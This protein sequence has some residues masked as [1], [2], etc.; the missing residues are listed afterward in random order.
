M[1]LISCHIENF[2]KLHDFDVDFTDRIHITCEENGWGKSTFA[3]FVRAMF[4]GLEGKRRTKIEENDFQRYTPW[5]GGVFGGR[6][7]FETNGKQYTLRR[8][9]GTG[10]EFE[11]RE[12]ATNL[13]STDFTENIGIEL[14]RVDRESFMRTVFIGQNDCITCTTDDINSKIGN[15]TDNTNDMNSYAKADE[16]LKKIENALTPRSIKGS[17]KKREAEINE[18]RREVALGESIASSIATYQNALKDVREQCEKIKK[19]KARAVE[20]QTRVASLQ[21]TLAKREEWENLKAVFKTR[22]E[23]LDMARKKFPGEVPEILEIEKAMDECI[24][25][26]AVKERV[27]MYALTDGEKAEVATLETAFGDQ[28]PSEAEIE[29]IQGT[30]RQIENCRK[31]LEKKQTDLSTRQAI[32]S[33]ISQTKAPISPLVTIGG[34]ALV[35]GFVLCFVAIVIGVVVA[36]VGA[37]LLIAGLAAGN[38]KKEPEIPAEIV[39]LEKQVEQKE[40]EL[41]EL[42]QQVTTYL[43]QYEHILGSF[44]NESQFAEQL[45]TLNSKMKTFASLSGKREKYEEAKKTYDCKLRMVTEFLESVSVSPSA[46]MRKQLDEMKQNVREYQ[47][48]YRLFVEVSDNLKRFESGIDVEALT[49][50]IDAKSLPDLETLNSEVERLTEEFDKKQEEIREKQK[51]LEELQAQFEEWEEKKERLEE[52]YE[53]QER[54][55]AKY[56]RIVAAREYLSRAKES[57]TARYVGPILEKFEEYYARIT[58]DDGTQF[59]MDANTKVTVEEY[60][61]QRDTDTLSAGYQDLIGFCLRIAFVDAMYQEETPMLIMDDPFVNLDDKKMK[62]AKELLEYIAEKYQIIYFTCSESRR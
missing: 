18:L 43:K 19:D 25:M 50:E 38:K 7:T 13:P 31:E 34:I 10:A 23:E 12:T 3:A 9:F 56:K 26:D 55:N 49:A 59:Y 53:V 5:Q 48:A 27:Q 36:L 1:R 35:V 32:S 37:A 33:A 40:T 28:M 8:T 2:G 61:K 47:T 11:L 52:L 21:K 14:F 41:S 30:V 58:G 45:Y 44:V 51:V 6:I 62:A 4:Y 60:G 42:I 24:S 20:E 46:D 39:E 54:E 15:L 16:I 29:K 57:I 22:K 17:L